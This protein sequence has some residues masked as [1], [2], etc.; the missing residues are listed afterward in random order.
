[1]GCSGPPA[2]RCSAGW[3]I[4]QVQSPAPCSDSLTDCLLSFSP[5]LDQ[6]LPSSLAP[7]HLATCLKSEQELE[8][9]SKAPEEGPL[10]W[11][12]PT[13]PQRC[14]PA[15]RGLGS[16]SGTAQAP[17]A[18]LGLWR[19]RSPCPFPVCTL[20]WQSTI[21]SAFRALCLQQAILWLPRPEPAGLERGPLQRAIQE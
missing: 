13:L 19:A 9:G 18:F 15:S 2:N 21:Q 3:G 14:E 1:M 8:S 16:G 6:A 17:Q 20:F 4:T 5:R 12:A 7:S 10:Q 11:L